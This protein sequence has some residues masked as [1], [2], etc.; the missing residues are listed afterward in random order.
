M[1]NITSSPFH[2]VKFSDYFTYFSD[3]YVDRTLLLLC[4]ILAGIYQRVQ[5]MMFYSEVEA[6]Y[7][8]ADVKCTYIRIMHS[9]CVCIIEDVY[10]WKKCAG[11][12]SMSNVSACWGWC[13]CRY[14][15]WW[16]VG[17]NVTSSTFHHVTLGTDSQLSCR[18]HTK[19]STLRIALSNILNYTATAVNIF[20]FFRFCAVR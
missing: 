2:F 19:V 3:K 6:L 16:L 12:V 13:E 20:L 14:Y 10:M 5:W 1:W 15:E 7:I 4:I 11:S 8:D 18:M 9:D 17:T